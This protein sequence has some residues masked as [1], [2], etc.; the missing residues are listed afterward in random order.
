MENNLTLW[1]ENLFALDEFVTASYLSA[2]Q[3]FEEKCLGYVECETLGA[4]VPRAHL[5]RAAR[6][7]GRNFVGQFRYKHVRVRHGL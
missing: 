3:M 5:L 6:G 7:A 2:L 1:A 4:N